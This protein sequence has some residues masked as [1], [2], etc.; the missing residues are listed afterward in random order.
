[1]NCINLRTRTKKYRKY[2]FCKK[3]NKQITLLECKNC[4]EFNF[5]RNKP[6]KKKSSKQ[7]KIENNRYSILTN[8]L[9]HCYIC[10]KAKKQD[11]HEIFGGSNRRK[12]MEWGLVIPICRE[13]HREWD[14]NKDLKRQIRNE[15]KTRFTKIYS[16]EKFLMEF[17]KNYIDKEN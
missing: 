13:C 6:I 11:F 16:E 2:F 5:K 14:V 9:E 8:D 15:A 17:G 7:R 4:L 10:I 12:S 1:M 3:R